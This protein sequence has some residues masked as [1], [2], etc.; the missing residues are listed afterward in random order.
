MALQQSNNH[1]FSSGELV[2][3]T[4]LNNVKAVQTDTASNNASFTG[5]SG[6]LTYDTTN[7]KIFVHDGSTAGGREV[8]A[9]ANGDI[10]TPQLAD[11]A[12]TANKIASGAVTPAKIASSAITSVKINSDAVT[13]A[14]IAGNAVT[15]SAISDNAVISGK[16]S[17]GAVTSAKIASGAVGTSQ[18]ADGSITAAKL[19]SGAVGGIADGSVTT[20]KLAN[21]AVTNAKIGAGA[22]GTTELANDA[23]T[24]AKLADTG[25]SA[26]SY[27]NSNITVDAQGR[28]TSASNG[29][30]SSTGIPRAIIHIVGGSVGTSAV[31]IASVSTATSSDGYTYTVNFSSAISNAVPVISLAHLNSTNSGSTPLGGTTSLG[32]MELTNNKI[33]FE[34]SQG[35]SSGSYAPA[36]VYGVI[37]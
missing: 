13:S 27:T 7:N 20:A 22:V 6:Q 24:S 18:V 16:I 34:I 28:V 37:Y 31:N 5:S 17:N 15:S 33:R 1:T 11:S 32:I 8:G 2:T 14:K 3:A 19:A 9:I 30:S 29:S 25:V 12:V 26:G 4:K 21:D 23:V 35:S 36:A 10:G